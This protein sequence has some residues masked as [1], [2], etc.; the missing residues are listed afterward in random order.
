MDAGLLTFPQLMRVFLAVTM[1]SQAVGSAM[2]WGP[3]RAKAHAAMRS[4]F[5][6]LDTPSP[7]DP[8]AGATRP[9]AHP[10]RGAL[11]FK[12]VSFSYPSRKD[13]PV[14]AGFSLAIAPGE[15]VGVVGASGCGKSTLVALAERFYD[16]DKGAVCLDGVDLR[17]WGVAELRRALGLVSQE[18]ALFADSI[19]YNIGYGTASGEKPAPGKAAPLDA[20]AVPVAGMEVPD[21]VR[22]AA[23]GANCANFIAELPAGFQTNVGARGS[24]L[25]G[26]QR[27][28]VAIARAVL[29]EPA[30][31]LLD[32]ATAA[33]DSESERVVQAAL[34]AVLNGERGKQTALIVAHRLST[35]KNCDRIVVVAGGAVAEAGTHEELLAMRGRYWRLAQQQQ[36][37]A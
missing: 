28:R 34:D 2:S 37:D 7:I 30:V 6:L 18:P 27:Q 5:Q 20:A 23:A 17:A 11:E 32:E 25:S 24:Q 1:A 9:A 21:A 26:G 35:L 8:L 31:M 12:D 13:V 19:A 15:R 10:P 29:R 36:A 3:D 33:L 22:A 16:P 4:I 14:L